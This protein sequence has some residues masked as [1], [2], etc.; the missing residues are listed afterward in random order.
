MRYKRV[1]AGSIPATLIAGLLFVS[2]SCAAIT[3]R[4]TSSPEASASAPAATPAES[5]TPDTSPP[6]ASTVVPSPSSVT[7]PLA[8]LIITS[9]TFHAAEVG[10]AYAPVT[11]GAIGGRAPYTWTANSGTLPTGLTLS[12]DG[13][14][15]GTPSVAG[16]FSFVVRVDDA[17]GG[18]AGVP[19]SLTVAR[20]LTVSGSCAAQACLVE[21]GC[22]TVCGA[23]G[24]Q[25]GGVGPF[26]YVRDPTS[27][28]LPP[29][30][31][32]NRLALT[33]TFTTV[34]GRVPFS[35]RVIVTDSL[36]AT[37][38]VSATFTVFQHITFT[39]T[40]ATCS[41]Y[42]VSGCS[43]QQLRYSGGT[44]GGAPTVIAIVA[45]ASA[46][47]G[48]QVTGAPCAPVATTKLPPGFTAFTK[49]GVVY[50]SIAASPNTVSQY[51]GTLF[52][53]LRD[54]SPCGAGVLCTSGRAALTVNINLG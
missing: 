29:G 40:T 20:H 48:L 46:C 41:G 14:V 30:T 1:W 53:T 52:L 17:A 31:S 39:V 33:G 12:S 42:Y 2:T 27:G 47:T 25:G 5:P 24:S 10:V 3:A 4:Q 54:Q 9:V 13:K 7:A 28:S 18:A 38:N 26:K 45:K 23:F 43:T 37:A 35:F 6:P 11:L 21:Q 49:G 50:V 16:T 32:L 34:S 8:K 44:P 15:S 19:R 51:Y 22:V 36:G